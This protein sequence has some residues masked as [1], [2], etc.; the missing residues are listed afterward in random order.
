MLSQP[1]NRR[2]LT[3]SFEL[4]A[5]FKEIKWGAWSLV[6]LYISLASGIIVGLQYDYLTPFYS[7]T[8]FDLLAPYGRYFRSLHFFSSQFFFFFCCLHLWSIYQKTENYTR[9]EWI[10]LTGSLPLIILLLFTGYIL[11]G[12]NTGSSAGSIA[13]NIVQA[14]PVFGSSFNTLFF[15]LSEN[16]LRK[17]FIHHVVTIDILFLI[18]AYN[19]LRIYRIRIRD[20][21]ALVASVLVFSVF[22]SAPF[23]P[24]R[25]GI[26]YIAG[27]WFFLGLQELLRYL[28]PLV[29]GVLF[30][31]VFLIALLFAQPKNRYARVILCFIGIWLICY[32]FLSI[33]AWNR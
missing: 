6:A 24:D 9:F 30:P 14:I 20:N 13:E 15:S 10:R 18:F 31:G 12:D 16:G 5:A 22:I 11:R 33:V 2:L 29:A 27:P 32:T 26:S 23:D 3:L 7:T 4:L 25:L 8:S 21:L 17:V 1:K 19:H 28:P